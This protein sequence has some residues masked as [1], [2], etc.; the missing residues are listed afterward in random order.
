MR[1]PNAA[2]KWPILTLCIKLPSTKLK[3][4]LT[5]DIIRFARSR[6]S[7]V[8]ST[9][10]IDDD[11][12]CDPAETTP[13]LESVRAEMSSPHLKRFVE[14][15]DTK[16]DALREACEAKARS[17]LSVVSVRVTKKKTTRLVRRK[18]ATLIGVVSTLGENGE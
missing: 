9:S 15:D 3:C 10:A 1:K 7:V 2:K 8:D 14:S 16:E 5:L 13:L 18:K 17:D 11:S 4:R 12:L 6:Y